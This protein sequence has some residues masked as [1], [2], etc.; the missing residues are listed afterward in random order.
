[1]ISTCIRGAWGRG[2]QLPVQHVHKAL[3]YLG[4]VL[5]LVLVLLNVVLKIFFFLCSLTGTV[6][7]LR[8]RSSQSINSRDG[9]DSYTVPPS[10]YRNRN[11]Y[12]LTYD[13]Y[14]PV[15]NRFH[16]GECIIWASGGEGALDT[17]GPL[18]GIC[19]TPCSQASI[20]L[21]EPYTPI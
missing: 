9:V 16:R 4:S 13:S 1:V 7:L 18:N 6:R 5:F 17:P 11:N 20:F 14:G 21:F 10:Q 3:K 8:S 19:V 15:H 2:G 12:L